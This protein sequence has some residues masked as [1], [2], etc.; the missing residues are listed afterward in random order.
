MEYVAVDQRLVIKKWMKEVEK[1]VAAV[2]GDD[3]DG[4]EP[5]VKTV[6]SQ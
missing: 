5:V 3:G 1:A 6:M 4:G 2:E